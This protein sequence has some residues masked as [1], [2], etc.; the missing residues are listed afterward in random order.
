MNDSSPVAVVVLNWNRL[1]DTAACCR[2]LEQQSHRVLDV[3]V[4]DNGSTAN[5]ATDL[6]HAC[7]HATVISL[8]RNLGFASGNNTAIKAVLQQQRPRAFWLL[9]ND[10]VV[11]PGTLPR[12]LDCL[13][14]DERVGAVGSVICDMNPPHPVQAWGGGWVSPWLGIPL[15]C[16]APSGRLNYLCGASLLLRT[17]ALEQIGLLDEGFFF[18]F[19]DAD[20]SFRLRE[21]GWKLTVA[22]DARVLHK[23]GGT[24]G[25]R[26]EL[27]ARLYR[28]SLIRF[29]RK[30]SPLPLLP[31]LFA[32]ALRLGAAGLKGQ[33]SVIRGTLAGWR[34]GWQANVVPF[35]INH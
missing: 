19:E 5:T 32:T 12:M 23:G 35:T 17:T 2:S 10:T 21:A 8:D 33:S 22:P 27:L 15:P 11:E 9:N 25:A 29:L 7:P 6:R 20:Y 16:R 14:A 4:V 30:H 26:N 28:Q 1:D 24:I 18:Y 31:A 3:R 13:D 34:E